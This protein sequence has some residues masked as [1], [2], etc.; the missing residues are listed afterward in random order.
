[1]AVAH[2]AEHA[3]AHAGRQRLL[4]ARIEGEEAQHQS[5]PPSAH[6]ARRAAGAADTGSSV[7]ATTPSTCAVVAGRAARAIGDEPRLV[8]VAQRQVQHEVDVAHEAELG[9]RPLGRRRL[10]R[11]APRP[12]RRLRHAA[13]RGSRPRRRFEPRSLAQS[14]ARP[15]LVDRAD[16]S[17]LAR[18][19]RSRFRFRA[20]ARADRAA[21]GGRAQR[22]APARRP[23]RA[24]GRPHA[25]A[26]CPAL[27]RDGRSARRQRHRGDQ[28]APA[29]REGERRRGRGAGR[30][31][32][33]DGDG[34][35]ACAR[36]QVAAGRDRVRFADA[37]DAEVLGRAGGDGSLF[38]LRFPG[39]PYRAARTRT[40]TCRCRRTSSTR[41]RADDERRYQTVF[42]ARAR[43][44]RGTDRR[45]CTSTR[46]CSPRSRRAASSAAP[47]TLHVGAGTFQPVRGTT[48]PAT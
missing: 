11:G 48:S 46:R 9:E 12:W 20:S 5:P 14:T 6:L 28:G 34:A 39:D 43:R 7:S 2:L 24:A 13:Q 29:R 17:L 10:G 37:F 18:P 22:L 21:P 27:L 32:R 45:R 3:H 31:G 41:R 30:A 1:M 47:I 38:R 33:A 15:R 19:L 23:R 26:I 40:A 35:R 36:E 16:R 4:L 42:A 44:G 8:L 25:S